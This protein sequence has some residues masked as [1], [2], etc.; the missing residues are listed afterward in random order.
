MV[1]QVLHHDAYHDLLRAQTRVIEAGATTVP[2]GAGFQTKVARLTG[3]PGFFWHVENAADISLADPTFD[4]VT[5]QARTLAGL[6]RVSRELLADS[7][8]LNSAMNHGFCSLLRRGAR[9]GC[10]ARKRQRFAADGN[11]E[12]ERRGQRLDGHERRGADQLR[13]I[14]DGSADDSRCKAV[15]HADGLHLAAAHPRKV[16]IVASGHD[17]TYKQL[18]LDPMA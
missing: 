2:L 10:F 18:T 4:Q 13:P 17:R 8:N 11:L 3:D 1:F 7:L 15:E 5:F 9:Q 16:S 12:H 6:I 14:S